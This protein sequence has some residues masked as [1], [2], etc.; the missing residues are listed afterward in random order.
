MTRSTA[1]VD[2][3]AGALSAR[4]S[5]R[6]FFA[7][8]AVVGTAVA[9]NPITY[10]LTPGDAYA[11]VCSCQGQG[12]ACGSLCCDGYTEFCCTLTGRNQCPPGSLLAGWWKVDGSGFCN[13]P[14]Y[15]MDCNAPCNGCGCGGTG[16]CDGGCSGTGCGCALGDCNNRKAGCTKF[17]YGQCNQGVAC[18]GPII[19]RIVTCIAP[20]EIDGTC[21]TTARYDAATAFHD[22][23]CLHSVHGNVDSAAEG[24]SGNTIRVQGWALDEDTNGPIDV[25]IYVDGNGAGVAR[26][27]RFRGDIAAARPG[28]GP[29][30]GF[31]VTIPA[32]PGVRQVC[33][34]GI[35]VGPLGN[36]NA[37]L[38]CRTVRVGNPF[39]NLEGYTLGNG[40]ITLTGWVIDPDTTGPVDV[41]VYVDGNGAGA[42]KAN[43]SRPDVGQSFPAYGPNHGFSVTVPIA[44]GTHKV[45]VYAI[46]VGPNGTNNPQLGCFDVEIGTP[47]GNVDK[48]DPAGGGVLV[49]GWAVD[50][51]D[52]SVPITVDFRID[53][54][55]VKSEVADDEVGWLAWYGLG[56]K[57][58]FSTF[59]PAAPGRRNLSVTARNIGPGTNKV[60]SQRTVDVWTGN[61]FGNLEVVEAGPG[62]VR[63][64][65]WMIDPDSS[66]PI[67][68]HVYVNGQWGGLGKANVDR[69]DVGADYPGYGR[70][71][72]FDL[73]VP[74]P[75]GLVTVDVHAINVGPGNDNPRIGRRQVLVGGNPFG[76]LEVVQ[77]SSGQIKVS[78]WVIDPD[79]DGAVELHVYVDGNGAGAIRADRSRPDVGMAYPLYGANH[80]FEAT[81]PIARG[82]RNVCVYAINVATGSSNPLMGCRTVTVG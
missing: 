46:N 21:T 66:N 79:T 78:G 3:L 7:R 11:Q 40:T 19:C 43:L 39:G 67:D 12:C 70:V 75:R 32:A 24:T 1:L 49:T 13:G 20:W 62:K 5:R 30:H 17:R 80:G 25:H 8:S 76:N 37:L 57:H 72:G 15:Y 58:G 77:G 60:I 50:R 23:P 41:H 73:V 28:M 16:V 45:C 33:A 69:P 29:Y 56:T 74:S 54:N 51:D 61:P 64:R 26:A 48:V 9:A 55:L 6:G 82:T 4:M 42:G 34:Y 63:V 71:H 22:R 59:V 53:G 14:R 47:I 65:G 44:P 35:N 38:G 31:D 10:A 18:V 52:P 36:G 27:D 81:F 68:V 2:K